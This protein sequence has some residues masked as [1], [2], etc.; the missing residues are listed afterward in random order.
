MYLSSQ[1][2]NLKQNSKTHQCILKMHWWVIAVDFAIGFALWLRSIII[3]PLATIAYR[4]CQQ[5]TPCVLMVGNC[6][7]AHKKFTSFFDSLPHFTSLTARAISSLSLTHCKDYSLS[8]LT[9]YSLLLHLHLVNSMFVLNPHGVTSW[10]GQG[11]LGRSFPKSWNT[12]GCS[13]PLAPPSSRTQHATPSTTEWHVLQGYA[14][15]V[16]RWQRGKC[17]CSTP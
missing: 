2:N 3:Q 6:D 15:W 7:H 12:C 14:F 11:F 5:S 4:L 17:S 16:V 9:S 8:S 1:N 10:L 13:P